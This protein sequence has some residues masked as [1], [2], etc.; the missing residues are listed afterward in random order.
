MNK[1]FGRTLSDIGLFALLLLLPQRLQFSS[2]TLFQLQ[3]TSP[4]FLIFL[5]LLETQELPLSIRAGVQ[6]AGFAGHFVNHLSPDRAAVEFVK[7]P[8]RGR[9]DNDKNGKDNNT[10][11]GA[12]LKRQ[13]YHETPYKADAK[14]DQASTAA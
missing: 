6:A 2:L 12:P 4:F 13:V 14:R 3:I 5:E 11:Q 10:F 9:H 7:T 8:G 1:L